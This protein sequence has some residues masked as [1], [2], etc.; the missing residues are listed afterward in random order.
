MPNVLEQWLGF[1][2]DMKRIALILIVLIAIAGYLF[3]QFPISVPKLNLEQRNYQIQEEEYKERIEQGQIEPVLTQEIKVTSRGF[4]P[5]FALIKYTT[6][7]GGA[8][9]RVTNEDSRTRY[10]V[11]GQGDVREMYPGYQFTLTFGRPVEIEIWDQEDPNIR[12]K[13]F[14]RE[15]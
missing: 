3:L 6:D 1:K 5:Q 2:V 4:E 7:I 12:G 14:V 15:V 8:R 9:V 13:I 10:I 11:L